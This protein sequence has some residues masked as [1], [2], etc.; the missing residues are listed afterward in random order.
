VRC[1]CC[2]KPKYHNKFLLLL[3]TDLAKELLHTT[4]CARR[5][6]LSTLSLKETRTKRIFVM[7]GFATN[8]V[9]LPECTSEE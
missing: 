2:C 4:I 7:L 9:S 8:L 5:S 3:F 6:G 1:S